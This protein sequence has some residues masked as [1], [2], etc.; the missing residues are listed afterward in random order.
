MS[1]TDL[2]HV[3]SHEFSGQLDND[4]VSARNTRKAL[5]TSGRPPGRFGSKAPSPTRRII[6]KVDQW[7]Y[8]DPLVRYST[9]IA[10]HP[11]GKV[12]LLSLF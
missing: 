4:L 1:G 5:L 10:D 6:G 3:T 11:K 2:L 9:L 12:R 7:F 8:T